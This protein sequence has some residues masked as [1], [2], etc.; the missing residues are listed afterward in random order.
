[1]EGAS[2]TNAREGASV[3]TSFDRLHN[4]PTARISLSHRGYRAFVSVPG[5]AAKG[6]VQV[7][8]SLVLATAHGVSQYNRS[9]L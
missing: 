1:V 7:G 9:L 6:D 4:P 3:M 2:R 5:V 8:T